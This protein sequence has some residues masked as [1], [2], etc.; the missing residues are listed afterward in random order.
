M[1]GW[2]RPGKKRKTRKKKLKKKG[3]GRKILLFHY[4]KWP[5]SKIRFENAGKQIALGES[6]VEK[7]H[8]ND[9]DTEIYP[10]IKL[11]HSLSE[12]KC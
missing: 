4:Q 7:V 10:R 8:L 12:L 3:A 1:R 9:H 5:K 2:S 6:T 11:H